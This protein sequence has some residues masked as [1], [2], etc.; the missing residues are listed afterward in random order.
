[1]SNK[2]A[3][4]KYKARWVAKS[5]EQQ[6]SI[7]YK[8]MFSLVAKSYNICIL[9]ALAVYY[10]WFIEHFDAV[11]AYLN[12]NIDVLLY[13]K[14]LNRY[15]QANRAALLQNTIYSLKQFACQ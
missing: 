11:I 1:M 15:K 14:L 7:D 13:V 8:K 9:F 10:S 2:G 6:K 5:F 4:S 12:S 3:I